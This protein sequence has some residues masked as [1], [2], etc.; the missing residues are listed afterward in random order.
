MVDANR[1]IDFS[2]SILARPIMILAG[3]MI[4]L[5]TVLQLGQ[6]G[7]DH[8]NAAN[9]WLVSMFAQSIWNL[10]AMRLN[11][12]AMEEVLR[13]WPLVLVSAGLGILMLRMEQR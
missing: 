10:L 2:E 8:I 7:Y 1:R 5:G 13:F 12:P 6:L 4:L 11:A 9:F 3:L